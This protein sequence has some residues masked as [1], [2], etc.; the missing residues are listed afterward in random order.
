[1]AA[2]SLVIQTT[3]AELLQRCSVASFNDAFPEDGAFVS[4]TINKRRYWYF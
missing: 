2:P 3:Y 4:K 1:M